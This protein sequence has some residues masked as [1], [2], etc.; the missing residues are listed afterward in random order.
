MATITQTQTID[1][2][3]IIDAK[4]GPTANVERW[5]LVQHRADGTPIGAAEFTKLVTRPFSSFSTPADLQAILPTDVVQAPA[6]VE[7]A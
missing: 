6:A 5:M 4:N 1:R 3:Q 7:A 2:I